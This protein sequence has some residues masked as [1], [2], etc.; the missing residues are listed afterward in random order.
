MQSV[1]TNSTVEKQSFDVYSATMEDIIVLFLNIYEKP[2]EGIIREIAESLINR[3]YNVS[4][5]IAF[6]PVGEFFC[7]K[8]YI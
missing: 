7:N 4:N 6:Q 2:E 3:S 1:P 5:L 8:T